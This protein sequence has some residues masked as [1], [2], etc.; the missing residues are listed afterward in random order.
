M[1]DDRPPEPAELHA[2]LSRAHPLDW[3][4][5]PTRQE[6]M[7]KYG[8]R[9]TDRAL[10]LLAGAARTEARITAD[11]TG[12]LDGGAFAYHLEN[13][14]KSPESLARKLKTNNV[15]RRPGEE[16]EDVL[17][18]TVGVDRPDQ[19]VAAAHVVVGRLQARG[20]SVEAAHHSYVERSRYKGLHAFLRGHGQLIELQVHSRESLAV[21]EE[22]TRPYEIVRDRDRPKKERD[23]QEDFCIDRSDTLTQPAGIDGL[24]RLGGVP[25][26][27]RHYVKRVEK[28]P[29][30]LQEPPPGQRNGPQHQQRDRRRTNDGRDEIGR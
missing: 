12:S 10:R 28:S 11:V 6:I 5:L 2:Q 27:V 25:V 4:D 13:R 19:V 8:R 20:W 1:R 30:T 9:A 3:G 22:T 15:Y 29:R 18:Y 17:R 16:P 24:T 21:K 14:L 23:E 26:V 7:A